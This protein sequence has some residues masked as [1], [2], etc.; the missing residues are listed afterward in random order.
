MDALPLQS[1]PLPVVAVFG[2]IGVALLA[3][4]AREA[5]L[6]LRY[7]SRRPTPV[8]ELTGASDQ[9]VVS[10]I[11]RRAERTI[12]AP[13]TGRDCLAYGWRV[14]DLRTVRGLDGSVRTRQYDVGTD[15][16]AVP[17]LVED[18]TGSV[19]VDPTGA[20]L[21]LAEEWV[22]EPARDP[23]ERADVLTGGDQLGGEARAREYY[24]SRLDV[25]ETVTVGGQVGAGGDRL[26]A[27]EVGLRVTGGGT[28]VEDATPGAAVGR[29]LRRAAYAAAAGAAMLAVLAVL[30]GAVAP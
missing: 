30:T 26:S 25:G 21:R 15:R 16:D 13:I 28:V 9:V 29:A 27:R 8:G 14:S 11:A 22:R 17:F 20:E 2:L 5:W 12:E 1:A 4:A 7:R 10:G 18:D 3:V 19:L 6:A 24:E 23:V